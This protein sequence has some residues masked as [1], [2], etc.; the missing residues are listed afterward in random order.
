MSDHLPECFGN[1]CSC[2]PDDYGH[3][4]E[5]MTHSCICSLLLA[6]EQ[7]V[8]EEMNRAW[9]QTVDI[10]S[11]HTRT[12]TLDAAREAVRSLPPSDGDQI[13]KQDA[14]AVIDALR[15]EEPMASGGI[16]A[17]P[18]IPLGDGCVIPKSGSRH[19]GRSHD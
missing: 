14:L 11:A 8:E 16:Y 15:E 12:A 3:M 1:K 9:Q 7:R 17:G 5:C 19:V 6:R 18:S 2:E 13:K 4:P 10:A